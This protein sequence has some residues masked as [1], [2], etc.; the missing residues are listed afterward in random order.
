ML[1]LKRSLPDL[2]INMRLRVVYPNKFPHF[3]GVEVTNRFSVG[4]RSGAARDPVQLS[5]R[6]LHACTSWPRPVCAAAAGRFFLRRVYTVC[7]LALP[8]LGAPAA[9]GLRLPPTRGGGEVGSR[10]GRL[11][12]LSSGDS[13]VGTLCPACVDSPR[14]FPAEWGVAMLGNL[15][16]D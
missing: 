14:P 9:A 5:R 16:T 4:L 8:T 15:R 2:P 3:F 7:V 6:D 1:S 13:W 11:R 10:A 12:C